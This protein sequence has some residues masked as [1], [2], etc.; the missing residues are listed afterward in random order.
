MVKSSCL[1]QSSN[2]RPAEEAPRPA[3]HLAGDVLG[4]AQE[5]RVP[6]DGELEIA[7][8]VERHRVDLAERVLAVEHPAVGAGEQRVGDVAQAALGR[9]A[10]PGGGARAL[11]PLALEVGRDLAAGEAAFAGIAHT[12]VGARNERVGFEKSESASLEG[13]RLRRVLRSVMIRRRSR[14]SGASAASAVRAA[15]VYTSGKEASRP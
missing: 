15:V 3:V 9:G 8:V 6:V 11:D 4:D 7:L 14:L 10:R 2:D 12:D 1:R 5:E 13:P